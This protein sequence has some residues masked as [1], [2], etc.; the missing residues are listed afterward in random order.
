[1]NWFERYGIP[2]LYFVLLVAVAC[3]IFGPPYDTVENGMTAFE[4]ALAASLPIGY[5][6]SV[7]S[8]WL[9]YKVPWWQVHHK[10]WKAA[11]KEVDKELLEEGE[12]WWVEAR[13]NILGRWKLDE[14]KIPKGIEKGKWLQE[15]F[16]KRF[17]VLAIN[18]T[19]ILATIIGLLV[20]I[21]MW[22]LRFS[23]AAPPDLDYYRRWALVAFI[24]L[25]ILA[26]A[27]LVL[28]NNLLKEQARYVATEYYKDLRKEENKTR[29][30][31]S[32]NHVS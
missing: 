22:C 10:A 6:L 2:G 26:I 16:T 32:H 24:G 11:K 25:S 3:Y 4:V 28:S 21:I 7:T 18:S 23:Q 17:D 13:A 31:S 8:Q 5:I 1:M 12:E 27:V 29:T 20:L 15:W 30:S 9:Y 19:L 14:E